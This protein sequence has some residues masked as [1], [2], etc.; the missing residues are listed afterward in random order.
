MEGVAR[1]DQKRREEKQPVIIK[2]YDMVNFKFMNK[3]KGHKVPND[4]ITIN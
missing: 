4:L 1:E 2:G 3:L